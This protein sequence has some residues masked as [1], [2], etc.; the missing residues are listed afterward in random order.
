MLSNIYKT[1]GFVLILLL[2]SSCSKDDENSGASYHSMT[3]EIAESGGYFWHLDQYDD[4][5]SNFHSSMLSV[6]NEK[7][8]RYEY[9]TTSNQ[10]ELENTTDRYKTIILED[11]LWKEKDDDYLSNLTYDNEGDLVIQTREATVVVA[12]QREDVTG[13]KIELEK[14]F[15][16]E[17]EAV[18]SEGSYRYDYE[19]ID[20]D[21]HKY[22]K[23]GYYNDGYYD[24]RSDE[25]IEIDE[26]SNYEYRS[27]EQSY[28]DF[29]EF[30]GV[31]GIGS[32]DDGW[33]NYS[34]ENNISE[35]VYG[36]LYFTDSNNVLLENW[37]DSK[38]NIINGRYV[39]EIIDGY[40]VMKFHFSDENRTADRN[41]IVVNYG[42]LVEAK[43]TNA[44]V[45]LD[46][47]YQI[48]NYWK[49]EGYRALNYFIK[50]HLVSSYEPRSI[51]RIYNLEAEGYLTADGN[52]EYYIYNHV[53]DQKEKL[54][55]L[56]SWKIEYVGEEE[57][58]IIKRPDKFKERYQ[59]KWDEIYS[60]QDGYVRSGWYHNG[61]INED[62]FEEFYGYNET[63][64]GDI[65]D[66]FCS[67][68]S[69]AICN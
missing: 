42:G 38:N 61:T 33:Y 16:F 5:K 13:R 50:D 69:N 37:T 18:F 65:H 22:Y 14:D 12:F 43:I 56:G 45:I 63:A 41:V 19:L 60:V 27:Q 23:V 29:N 7:L 21:P 64:I 57:M 26:N 46:P 34:Y 8:L 54:D 58:L 66:A 44:Q 17:T 20:Y 15:S 11:G 24:P 25:W 9:N 2:L 10:Y 31:N 51:D 36:N 68:V 55:T 52:I 47:Y 59:Y 62:E 39:I 6:R 32:K 53:T 40:E 35:Q 4:N 28:V 67:D 1:V 48:L 49:K 3:R 30:I